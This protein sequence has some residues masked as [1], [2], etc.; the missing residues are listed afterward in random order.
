MQGRDNHPGGWLRVTTEAQPQQELE[1]VAYREELTKRALPPT[2]A[3]IR[4]FASEVAEERV[5]ESWVTRFINRNK[6]DLV[7]KWTTSMDRNR[8]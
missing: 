1:L 3:M 8:H 4:N 5:S 2:R 6:D 7:S